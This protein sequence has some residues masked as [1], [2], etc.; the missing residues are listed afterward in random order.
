MHTKYIISLVLLL[1]CVD[2]CDK[3]SVSNSGPTTNPVEVIADAGEP[4]PLKYGS[5]EVLPGDKALFNRPVAP[6]QTA[7]RLIHDTP[8]I[9]TQS[10]GN[11]S[12]LGAAKA[13]KAICGF[14][15]PDWLEPINGRFSVSIRKDGPV[16]QSVFEFKIN[17]EM[18]LELEQLIIEANARQFPQRRP[19]TFFPSSTSPGR[20]VGYIDFFP[21]AEL[22][23]AMAVTL[24]EN[25][26]V[27][28][29]AS[30][31]PLGWDD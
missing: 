31:G 3:R 28:L 18:R 15:P 8:S 13:F 10:S 14:N 24:E 29:R 20:R 12:Y 21:N 16:V 23:E 9:D 1:C 25:G 19:I 6:G 26:T 4:I 22:K 17:P 30:R 5:M 2:S 11:Y 27:T 7:R